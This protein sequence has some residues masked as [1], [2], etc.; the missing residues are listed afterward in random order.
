M[1]KKA[2][3]T[4]KVKREP[5]DLGPVVELRYSDVMQE[6]RAVDE[7][8]ALALIASGWVLTQNTDQLIVVALPASSGKE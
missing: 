2:K 5:V 4:T 3:N 1:T 7:E 8:E 6:S